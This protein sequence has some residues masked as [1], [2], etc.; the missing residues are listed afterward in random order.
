VRYDAG[1]TIDRSFGRS[2][3]VTTDID[4]MGGSDVALALVVQ[5][6][7]RLVAAGTSNVTTEVASCSRAALVRY[8]P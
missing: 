1:G 5:P 4:G 2:G 6:D 3:K 8:L 7:G